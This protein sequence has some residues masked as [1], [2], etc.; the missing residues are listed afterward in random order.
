VQAGVMLDKRRTWEAA[1]RY[2][3][4]DTNDS[5]ANDDVREVR[6]AVNYYYRRHTLKLQF[7]VGRV[8]TGLGPTNTAKRK[9]NE[10][11]VQ[12]QFIF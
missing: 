8:E 1:F 5:L 4:R 9:D 12:T 11:R 2:G 6:G 7:D 3:D 10:L